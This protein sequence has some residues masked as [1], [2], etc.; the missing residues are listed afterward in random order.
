M[1]FVCV[2]I[3]SEETVG[4]WWKEVGMLFDVSYVFPKN[5]MEVECFIGMACILDFGLTVRKVLFD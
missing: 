4:N 2:Q 3:F 1:V 5:G